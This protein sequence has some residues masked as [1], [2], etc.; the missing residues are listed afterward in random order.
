MIAKD[1]SEALNTGSVI[2]A[3]SRACRNTNGQR[4]ATPVE[5]SPSC[6]TC[7]EESVRNLPLWLVAKSGVE[8]LRLDS[9]NQSLVIVAEAARVLSTWVR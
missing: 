6:L 9:E 7:V 2:L 1:L 8:Y 5:A 3:A 4:E